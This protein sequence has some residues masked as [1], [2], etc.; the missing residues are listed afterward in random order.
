MLREI[1]SMISPFRGFS[2]ARRSAAFGG[3]GDEVDMDQ[4]PP[5]GTPLRQ[6]S[7]LDQ[8]EEDDDTDDRMIEDAEE[9]FSASAVQPASSNT[10]SNQPRVSQL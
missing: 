9:G 5:A 7:K 1:F 8:V 10:Q 6:E 3:G 4:E 2:R